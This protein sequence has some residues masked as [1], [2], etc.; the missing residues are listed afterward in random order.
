MGNSAMSDHQ[1]PA[2]NVLE[3]IL[4]ESIRGFGWLPS[5]E[6]VAEYH[7][8]TNGGDSEAAIESVIFWNSAFAGSAGFMTGLGSLGALPLTLPIN[9]VASFASSANTVSAIAKLRGYD[10]QSMPVQAMIFACLL[11]ESGAGILRAAG[12]GIGKKIAEEAFQQIPAKLLIEINQRV[13]FH[14]VTKAGET[15]TVNLMKLVPVVGG[16]VGGA[17]DATYVGTCGQMAK[18][19]FPPV[20]ANQ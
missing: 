18:Q 19:F 11:G 12:I 7:L 4:R 6:Q 16:A 15:S 10:V 2:W 20:S 17:I 9:L 5:V 14:L 1:N 13:G 3:W 8:E